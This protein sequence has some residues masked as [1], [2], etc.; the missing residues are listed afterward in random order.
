MLL[1]YQVIAVIVF[2]C[3]FL[4]DYKRYSDTPSEV[5]GNIFGSLLIGLLW[6]LA[7]VIR[8]ILSLR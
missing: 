5:F 8:F 2:I 6:P 4:G 7:I 3:S 1:V